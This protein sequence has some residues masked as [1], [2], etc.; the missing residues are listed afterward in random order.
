MKQCSHVWISEQNVIQ[1]CTHP[2]KKIQIHPNS[3]ITIDLLANSSI[4]KSLDTQLFQ[5]EGHEFRDRSPY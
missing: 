5:L 3:M 4:R 2:S 1:T